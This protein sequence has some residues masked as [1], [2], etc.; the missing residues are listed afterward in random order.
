MSTSEQTIFLAAIDIDDL[1]ERAEYLATA[2]G[3]NARLRAKVEALL[4]AHERSGEFLDQPAVPFASPGSEVDDVRGSGTFQSSQIELSFLEASTEPGSLGRL[5][6]YEVQEV[7][8]RGGCGI[9][10]RARDSKLQRVV[11]M[12]VMAPELA[13]TSPARKR[14]LRE[15]RATAAVRHENVV[16]IFS[17][18]EAPIPF[19]VMEYIDGENLQQCLNRTGPLDPHR[20]VEIGRQIASGL[21]AAHAKGLIHRD[22]KPANVLLE[23][24]TGAVKI[25]DFGLARSVDD[26]SLTQSGVIAGTPLYMSPEQALGR[27][28]DQRSDLFSLGSL[29]Y[30]LCSGRPPFR[31][32]TTFAVIKRVVEDDP[33]PIH[34]VLADVPD[35]LEQIIRRL[36]AKAPE[37]RFRSARE[38][39]DLLA[40][41]LEKLKQS[42]R[43]RSDIVIPR[44]E[45]TS[46][47]MTTRLFRWAQE[48]D[49]SSRMS[50]LL[51]AGLCGA[52]LA[53][54]F[55]FLGTLW[56]RALNSV[57]P[58]TGDTLPEHAAALEADGSESAVGEADQVGPSLSTGSEKPA[59][60][61]PNAE[62]GAPVSP[63]NDLR[64]TETLVGPFNAT[65]NVLFSP[66]E[67]FVIAASNG[68]HHEIRGGFRYHVAGTDN[69]VRVWD[70][71]TQK[72]VYRFRMNEGQK[73][74][75]I[76]LSVSSDSR[77]LAVASGWRTANGPSEPRVYVYDLTTGQR[78]HHL[79]PP[80]NHAMR[81]VGFSADGSRL[82]AVRS[83]S[84]GIQTWS[85]PE[86]ESLPDVSLL[87]VSLQ[88]EVPRLSW[89]PDGRLIFGGDWGR[90]G[91]FL[92]WE[93]A[94]GELL[95]R[96]DGHQ[97]QPQHIAC[98]GDNRVVVSGSADRTVRLWDR[99]TGE[100][101]VSVRIEGSFPRCVA[102][103]IDGRVFAC[104]TDDGRINVYNA[105][106]GALLGSDLRHEGAVFDVA[107]ST[108][109]RML[110]S[111]GDDE[112]VRLWRV[113]L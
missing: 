111:V 61:V 42:G 106:E 24:G 52:I 95:R 50:R 7:I 84:G 8:G 86:G 27:N 93:A 40:D 56:T 5:M 82:S 68:D 80:G 99:E 98:S 60:T 91:P 20:V 21:A 88:S 34:E 102:I 54:L 2:C 110:A 70:V 77:R 105:E 46:A 1:Q 14:F 43:V 67:R 38:V 16:N 39:A 79:V 97:S 17:V 65:V 51:F 87:G 31:A 25:T 83:G 32:P 69:S 100:E 92:C 26:A 45:P 12:K 3:D 81:T 74:G 4:E 44:S 10:L 15:A 47:T 85:L 18:E 104:G 73:Y 96:Y 72:E 103:S 94:T 28:I 33:R 101:K 23:R 11:A 22:I 113:P 19:L 49:G 53:T 29:L 63:V 109:G 107:F 57:A 78:V 64:L 37:E 90:S 59:P 71:A 35:W 13:T 62:T 6:H 58:A 108:S 30:V 9:V 75:P 36:H 89:S 55:L 41:C 48:G 112:T 76:G 66:D